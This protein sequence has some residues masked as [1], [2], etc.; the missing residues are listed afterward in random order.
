MNKK[1]K[2]TIT[3]VW[4]LLTRCYDAYCTNQLTP[5]LSKES[6]PL[7]S[8]LGM[9]W[10]P[11]LITL[12]LLSIYVIYAYY[13]SIF[14]P[15][16]LLPTEKGYTFNEF[17]AFAY[18][19]RKDIWV[20][21]FYKFPKDLNR[22]NQWMGYNLTPCLAFAGLVSTVM[23]LL[24]NNTEYYKTIHSAP[25]IYSI[26]IIG[27]LAIIYNWNKTMFRKYLEN[28]DKLENVTM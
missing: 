19:G 28:F 7:V 26:L 3:T 24:I 6:N 11:L 23:W 13:I 8:V 9:T 12:G 14:K 27:C 21:I 15:K 25:L 4:I 10:T 20:A 5:D 2:F 22:F 16:N 1:V 17:I 18:L